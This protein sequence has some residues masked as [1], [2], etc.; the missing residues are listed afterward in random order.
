M[1]TSAV[2][3]THSPKN[4]S[5]NPAGLIVLEGHS[6]AFDLLLCPG[7]LLLLIRF[8]KQMGLTGMGHFLMVDS[9]CPPPSPARGEGKI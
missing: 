3:Y 5:Q 8:L 2:S 4:I 7:L 1:E 9:L 6:K